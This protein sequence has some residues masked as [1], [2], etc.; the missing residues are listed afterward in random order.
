M[1][2]YTIKTYDHIIYPNIPK[3]IW[4]YWNNNIPYLIDKCIKNVYKYNKTWKIFL[5]NDSNLHKYINIDIINNTNFDSVQRKSDLIRLI[6]LYNFGGIW[7][8]ASILITK[9]LNWIININ[10]KTKKN[11]IVYYLEGFTTNK[12]F[13][14]IEN[15]FIACNKNNKFIKLWLDDFILF[16]KINYD[17]Y[18]KTLYNINLQDIN[19]TK[20]LMMHVIAQK[21]IQQ[22]PILMDDIY[23][24]ESYKDPYYFHIMYN[25][26]IKKIIEHI[27]YKNYDKKYIPKLIKLRNCERKEININKINKKSLFN[28]N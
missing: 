24:L 18:M 5:L 2:K 8:D 7:L 10:K 9:S 4:I 6:I 26:N 17:E 28:K 11:I 23:F 3:I 1:E 21:L 12:K 22:N 19:D 27:F 20:Y 25:W 13:P 16:L 15:W 14:V